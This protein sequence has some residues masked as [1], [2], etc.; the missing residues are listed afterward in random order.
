MHTAA[1]QNA[2]HSSP[3]L[4]LRRLLQVLHDDW[5]RL[6]IELVVLVLGITA[7]FALD[8]W[9]R[10]R[11][12]RQL[13]RRALEAMRENLV[14][15][16]AAL[17]RWQDRLSRMTRAYGELL[18][19]TAP[20]DS[21]DTYMDLGI[22]YV[23]FVRTDNAWQELAATGNSRLLRNRALLNEVIDMYGREYARAV[24]WDNINRQ[25]VLDRMIPYVDDHAPYNPSRTGGEVTVG[26][27]SAYRE[28]MRSDRFRNLL[29][30]NRD[31]KTAQ[32]TV[33]GAARQRAATLLGKLDAEL[34]ATAATG[35]TAP[36]SG[37][38]GIVAIGAVLVVLLGVVRVLRRAP[39]PAE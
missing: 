37:G 36:V 24:E 6:C 1:Q 13:E 17:A 20:A 32:R 26:L 19:G 12:D 2:R 25:L 22:S 23:V 27:A 30:T 16:T 10:E 31:F 11:E 29:A 38:T 7:S 35:G 39:P 21:I 4:P 9:R 34:A 15:D 18:G 3:L 5:P 33:Y 14:A 8:Q 28:L